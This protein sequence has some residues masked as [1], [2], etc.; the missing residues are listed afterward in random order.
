MAPA[1]TCAHV[2]ATGAYRYR[3]GGAD[4]KTLMRS[5]RLSQYMTDDSVDSVSVDDLLDRIATHDEDLATDVSR[6]FEEH[7]RQLAAEEDQIEEYKRQLEEAEEQ[8]AALEDEV[9]DLEDSL[10]RKQADFEN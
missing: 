4:V 1:A 2:A 5:R 7:D 6:I 3:S 10:K 8:I 9:E